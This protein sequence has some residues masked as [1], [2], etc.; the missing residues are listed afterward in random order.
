M[1]MHWSALWEEEGPDFP[2]VLLIPVSNENKF[3]DLL[4]NLEVAPKKRMDGSYKFTVL[5]QEFIL[6]FA[7]RYAYI[8]QP[9]TLRPVQLPNPVTL[10][11]KARSTNLVTA[12]LRVDQIAE[13]EKK[14]FIKNTIE[15]ALLGKPDKKPTESEDQARERLA[16]WRKVRDFF[17][18]PVLES[19]EI[20][21]TL[22]LDRKKNRWALDLALIPR[23]NTELA[24]LVKG[25][26]SGRSHFADLGGQ[27]PLALSARFPLPSFLVGKP[28]EW[29]EEVAD[30]KKRPLVRR[31]AKALGPTLTSEVVDVGF[32]MGGGKGMLFGVKVKNGRKLEGLLRDLVKD[33]PADE[34]NLWDIRWN[35]SR[36][37]E[38]R[39]H[40]LKFPSD[41]HG[42]LM[43]LDVF[44]AIQNDVVL[45]GAG[46]PLAAAVSRQKTPEAAPLVDLKR[47]IDQLQKPSTAPPSLVRLEFDPFVLFFWIWFYFTEDQEIKP[48]LQALADVTN[49]APFDEGIVK[50][51]RKGVFADL[52]KTLQKEKGTVRIRL[53]VKGGDA[54]RL[55]LEGHTF[56]FKLV[57]L[58]PRPGP[59]RGS[60]PAPGHWP[61]RR[62]GSS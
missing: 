19:R 3:L 1:Y 14:N 55:R 22:D 24:R 58:G 2:G 35:L 60:G 8:G 50:K 15:E 7:H 61:G 21:L 38:A 26:D 57:A 13:P 52:V 59:R 5:D 47:A 11:P 28:A 45:V 20:T 56:A 10:W 16:T 34:R 49:G 46:S 40:G 17:A 4:R 6:R 44:L 29:F 41:V 48:I 23:P 27:C 37:A 25:L 18:R 39:I 31:L 54:L 32:R 51:I 36:H 62:R 9:P 53:V 33:W 43:K 30:P 42:F 12:S